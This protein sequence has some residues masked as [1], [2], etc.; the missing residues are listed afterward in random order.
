MSS[1]I[2]ASDWLHW[3]SNKSLTIILFAE[4]CDGF[5]GRLF[6]CRVWTHVCKYPCPSKAKIIPTLKCW[7]NF[8]VDNLQREKALKETLKALSLFRVHFSSFIKILLQ[9]NINS[10][11]QYQ[12]NWFNIN[13]IWTHSFWAKW[14]LGVQTFYH[15]PTK[16]LMFYFH[17]RKASLCREKGKCLEKSSILDSFGDLVDPFNY[18]FSR[19][20][21]KS[22]TVF[23]TVLGSDTSKEA[24]TT[25]SILSTDAL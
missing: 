17:K 16:P 15:L 2:F 14:Q 1:F 19:Q 18:K 5:I 7:F 3:W 11:V 12:L 23:R 9:C 21:P 25:T 6:Y 24:R 8:N 13:S 20:R 10:F 22:H 4:S